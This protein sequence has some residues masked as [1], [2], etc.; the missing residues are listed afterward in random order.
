[1]PSG[2]PLNLPEKNTDLNENSISVLFNI[3]S[4]LHKIVININI[5]EHSHYLLDF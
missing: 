4:I 5:K 1:M 3:Y 2:L